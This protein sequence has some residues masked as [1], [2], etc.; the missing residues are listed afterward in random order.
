VGKIVSK[1]N[2]LF[3]C[4]LN[5]FCLKIWFSAI[6]VDVS[7]GAN[8]WVEHSQLIEENEEF[9]CRLAIEPWDVCS[10]ERDA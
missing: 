4:F 9:I 8:E 7:M 3:N 6:E 1:V 5:F 2:A 10:C